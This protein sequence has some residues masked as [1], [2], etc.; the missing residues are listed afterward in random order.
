[1][2]LPP[3][4]KYMGVDGAKRTLGNRCLRFA[5]PSEYDDHQDMTAGS[6]FPDE[7]ETALTILSDGFVDVIANS[8]DA[9]PTC[10]ASLRPKVIE[11]QHIFRDNPRAAQ[12]LKDGLKNEPDLNVFNVEHW[13][14]RARTFVDETNEFMQ[15]H[16]VLCVTTNNASDRMWNEY[17]QKS[18]GIVLRIEPNVQK[19]SKFQKFVPVTYQQSRPPIFGNT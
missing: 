9:T 7:I 6:L 17:A 12:A 3:L 2:T 11:L 1:M 16:R 19:D 18:Q 10:S 13:R 14:L 15:R 5:K 4:Y 8:Q